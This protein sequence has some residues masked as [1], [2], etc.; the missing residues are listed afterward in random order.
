MSKKSKNNYEE[1]LSEVTSRSEMKKLSKKYKANGKKKHRKAGWILLTVFLIVGLPSTYLGYTFNQG[2]NGV[3]RISGTFSG[4]SSDSKKQEG[5]PDVKRPELEEFNGETSANGANNI[6]IFGQDQAGGHADSIMILQLDGPSGKP[7]LLSIARDTLVII[8]GTSGYNKINAAYTIGSQNGE[9]AELLRETIKE[10][11]DIDCKYYATV[12]F[13]TFAE[14]INALFPKGVDITAKFSTVDG[15]QVDSVEVPDDLS[16]IGDGPIPTQ[17]IYQGQQMMDGQTLLNYARF[18]HDDENDFGRIKRQQQVLEVL[19]EQAKNPAV[20]L[21]TAKAAGTA[22]RYVATDVPNSF[23]MAQLTKVATGANEIQ[24]LTIPEEGTY[25]GG[26]DMYGGQ[27]L[28]IVDMPTVQE[29]ID[30]LLGQ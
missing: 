11:F 19:A 21:N 15:E 9:G 5:I 22:L 3:N 24:K 20:I 27:G 8:P 12:N 6:L 29:S 16:Q 17:T 30:D 23:I 2:L 7:R 25:V 10:T 18:R 28:N 14:V 13:G 4:K 1:L 26:M